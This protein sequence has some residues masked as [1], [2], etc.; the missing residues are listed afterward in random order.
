MPLQRLQLRRVKGWRVPEGAVRV[1]RATPWGNPF[2]VGRMVHL[3]LLRRWG[4]EPLLW[5]DW[6]RPCPDPEEAVYRFRLNLMADE[7]AINRVLTG[8]AGK[9][10]ACWCG[11]G[12]P[13]HAEVLLD[14]TCREHAY[15]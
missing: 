9:H 1:D 12:V 6:E 4:W 10:L 7:V 13:C 15:A 3:P 14:V 2:R 8:L 5:R 11:P